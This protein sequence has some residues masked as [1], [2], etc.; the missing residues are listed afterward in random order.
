[1]T[2]IPS[3]TAGV[4]AGGKGSRLGGL[5]KGLALFRGQPLIRQVLAAVQ[6]QSAEQIV[7]A[8]RNI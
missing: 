4:L 2:A 8:N 3:L 7:S 6:P 1:M 5:D